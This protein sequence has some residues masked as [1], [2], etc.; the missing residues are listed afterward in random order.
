MNTAVEKDFFGFLEVK[1]LHL[2]GQ[3]GKSVNF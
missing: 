1:W 2:T 3:M